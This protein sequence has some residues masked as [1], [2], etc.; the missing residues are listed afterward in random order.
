MPAV[1]VRSL[2]SIGTPVNGPSPGV[3]ARACSKQSVT[4]K[5]SSGFVAS[6]RAIA[7]VDEL[8]GGDVARAHLRGE[9][10][11]VGQGASVM[12]SSKTG[13]PSDGLPVELPDRALRPDVVGVGERAQHRDRAANAPRGRQR[14]RQRRTISGETP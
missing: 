13:R 11:R 6:A 2:T 4:R 12:R 7:A 3:V 10:E 5:F 8:V 14:S 1:S 9:G